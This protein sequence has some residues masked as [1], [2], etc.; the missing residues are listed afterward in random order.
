MK[1]NKT[2]VI[3][4]LILLCN[5]LFAQIS[6]H[7]NPISFGLSQGKNIDLRSSIP[8]ITM[9][10]LDMVSISKEDAEDEMYDM[11]RALGI[12]TKSM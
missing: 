5:N 7:E 2:I 6:T 9:P 4:G 1:P 8:T 12:H 11:P 10:G 3:L